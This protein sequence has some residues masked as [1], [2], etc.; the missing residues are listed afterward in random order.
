MTATPVS[1]HSMSPHHHSVT[2]N[3]SAA[4]SSR[5]PQSSFKQGGVAP[6]SVFTPRGHHK[7]D[8]VEIIV[9]DRACYTPTPNSVGSASDHE[10][11]AATHVNGDREHEEEDD[12][13]YYSDERN[14]ERTS[15]YTPSFSASRS[16]T[17]RPATRRFHELISPK[18]F[19]R[20]GEQHG[21]AG[22]VILPMDR[23]ATISVTDK[24]AAVTNKANSKRKKM[25]HEKDK[26]SRKRSR[27]KSKE[28][29]SKKDKERERKTSKSKAK[30]KHSSKN[31]DY[32]RDDHENV[33]AN[34]MN[35][36][37][38]S[39][40]DRYETDIAMMESEDVDLFDD[41]Q[42]HDGQHRKHKKHKK[43]HHQKKEQ[44]K[45]KREEENQDEDEDDDYYSMSPQTNPNMTDSQK[46]IEI[47]RIKQW[48]INETKH[49]RKSRTVDFEQSQQDRDHLAQIMQIREELVSETSEEDDPD[50]DEYHDNRDRANI[51]SQHDS[52]PMEHVQSAQHIEQHSGDHDEH[53]SKKEQRELKQKRFQL[54]P[55]IRP[56]S[57]GKYRFRLHLKNKS[58]AINS[59][60]T[61]QTEQLMHGAVIDE[62]DEM[63]QE[64]QNEYKLELPY[65]QK[66]MPLKLRQSYSINQEDLQN[67][68][69]PHL[70]LQIHDSNEE[71][72]A[73]QA[74]AV[75]G[76]YGPNESHA[77]STSNVAHAYD[78]TDA[79]S[80][81]HHHHHHHLPQS[82][83][84]QIEQNK[85]GLLKKAASWNLQLAPDTPRDSDSD[86]VDDVYDNN[87]LY[88]NNN[89]M[90]KLFLENN[91]NE[92]EK[93]LLSHSPSKADEDS[94]NAP[95][96][97]QKHR[98]RGDNKSNVNKAASSASSSSASS[99]SSDDDDDDD[100]LHL[101]HG[102]AKKKRKKLHHG[103][104]KKNRNGGT[105]HQQSKIVVSDR[106][107][108]NDDI[109]FISR[110]NE[111]SKHSKENYI[112]QV[113]HVDD[114]IKFEIE[115]SVIE[116]HVPSKA[117]K[118]KNQ[119]IK[120]NIHI[121]N[122][123][124]SKKKK[125]NKKHKS[126]SKG[127]HVY[128]HSNG[129]EN[130]GQHM[131][132]KHAV[133]DPPVVVKK[134]GKHKTKKKASKRSKHQTQHEKTNGLNR[135][136]S[137]DQRHTA[138][139]TRKSNESSTPRPQG[140]R[141]HGSSR[142]PK[143]N[144]SCQKHHECDREARS[145]R[146]KHE[147]AT[148]SKKDKKCKQIKFRSKTAKPLTPQTPIPPISSKYK[149]EQNYDWTE[150][151]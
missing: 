9:D 67:A 95:N 111:V 69:G 48:T 100:D 142:S 146:K 41:R 15:V 59:S 12:D 145:P 83:Q 78:V 120:I 147:S 79:A 123:I 87:V 82:S 66:A 27:S 89:K 60:L 109:L 47:D 76:P 38:C 98:A 22:N 70:S 33:N 50:V 135:A 144:C 19:H 21:S 44:E 91:D 99:L 113:R 92:L 30:R 42:R 110:N 122:D 68:F 45:R 25:K 5:T 57:A 127:N 115:E 93:K 129:D 35:L 143:R 150:L 53:H 13:G 17:G 151:V 11:E 62:D 75:V 116:Y 136:Y 26:K 39:T 108:E 16:G 74:V 58:G 49:K 51:Q 101:V 104:A 34:L 52:N 85:L 96:K 124:I 32:N 139:R 149:Q 105:V 119:N 107:K 137:M 54:P 72:T 36:R 130:I 28:R 84:L 86:R 133:T 10:H 126:P 3:E 121:N 40:H 103:K 112:D 71:E 46:L 140:H 8:T 56:Q 61:E 117:K 37:P 114:G 97:E 6:P 81:P 90:R 20:E 148:K 55:L 18:F 141:N 24:I 64:M 4:Y 88:P 94:E 106:Q 65:K 23:A 134:K 80:L 1:P 118:Q 131:H 43:Q 132:S 138:R 125:S 14:L 63:D 31:D 7:N 77:S 128:S 2:F 102:Q 29:R 73:N